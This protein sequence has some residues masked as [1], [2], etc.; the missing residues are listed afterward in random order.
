MRV[1]PRVSIKSTSHIRELDGLRGIAIIMVIIW[2]Y[3]A[4]LPK[5]VIPKSALAYFFTATNSFWTGVDLFFVLSG[6]LIGR[7]IITNYTENNFLK[8]FWVKRAC[9][10]L[11]V[12]L[13]LLT[14]CLITSELLDSRFKWLY[15][16]LMPWWSYLTFTQNWCMAAEETMGG[17][18]LG[19]TWSLAVEEQFYLFAPLAVLGL[20]I[21]RFNKLLLPLIALSCFAKVTWPGFH[22]H[23]GTLFRMDTLLVGMAIAVCYTKSHFWEKLQ[24]FKFAI[25]TLCAL[26]IAFTLVLIRYNLFGAWVFTWF[27]VLYGLVLAVSLLFTGSVITFFLRSKTLKFFSEIS[28]SLYMIH[29]LV[30]GTI[31]G[32]ASGQP[33]NLLGS[34][35]VFLTA[36]AFL[37]SCIIAWISTNTFEK[38][39]IRLGQNTPYTKVL[40]TSAK[41]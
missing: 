39:F 30:N 17:H 28:Y 37:S 38:F 41:S 34:K 13:V 23:V 22:C 19:I 40:Q 4:C 10:I 32:I 16:H 9:R 24:R 36:S 29:Q 8:A 3:V 25:L 27:A 26:N 20:G 15:N 18:F 2:H 7:I 1:N 5:A 35:S 33:P 12:Y 31:H 6:F 14:T 11:P 21:A